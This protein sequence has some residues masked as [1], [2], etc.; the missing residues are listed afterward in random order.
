MRKRSLAN[1]G[2]GKLLLLLGPGRPDEPAAAELGPFEFVMDLDTLAA[3]ARSGAIVRHVFRYREVIALSETLD[4]LPR[5]FA[6]VCLLRLVSRGRVVFKDRRGGQQQV[7]W[8]TPLRRAGH[9]LVDLAS[10]PA[11]RAR[12]QSLL[13][14]LEALAAIRRRMVAA[15]IPRPRRVLLLRTDLWLGVKAGGS[16]AHTAG[17]AN[18]CAESGMAAVVVAYEKNPILAPE[19]TE[20]ILAPP[21]RFWDTPELP[22]LAANLELE[23]ALAWYLED[24]RPDVVY[25]RLAALSF[26]GALTALRR[27][28]PLIVEYNGSEA[29]IARHWGNPFRHEALALRIERAVLDTADRIVVVSEPL[30]H[31]LIERGLAPEKILMV[32]NGVDTRRIHPGLD[33]ASA[34]VRLGIAP[35]EAVVGFIGSFGVWHGVPALV[36]AFAAL[37]ADHPEMRPAIRLLLIGDGVEKARIE[38]DTARLGIGDRVCMPGQVAQADAPRMLAAADILA[39]PHV[40][41]E[42]GSPFFGSPTKIF[43]YMALGR[44]IVASRLGQ[45]GD[46][47][48]DERTALLVEPGSVSALAGAFGR[49]IADPPLRSRIGKAARVEAE[50]RHDWRQRV[51]LIFS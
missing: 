40:P 49:A 8:I 26:A 34:R 12:I 21:R 31:E 13:S 44:C 28:L 42:D 22:A 39:A 48:E 38:A 11:A 41:N 23:S 16:V 4:C 30:R 6:L 14:E 36:E 32:P 51:E 37:L 43:E 35:E 5:P 19:V 46:V 33:G 9:Y 25:H 24:G 1:P 27:R 7:G 50:L 15:K 17:L 29:W 45:I 3:L 47:L 20:H 10:T 18:A 2:T